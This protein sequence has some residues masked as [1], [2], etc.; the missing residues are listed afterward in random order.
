MGGQIGQITGVVFLMLGLPWINRMLN[1]PGSG[2]WVT[3]YLLF[4]AISPILLGI[5]EVLAAFTEDG[6]GVMPFNIDYNATTFGIIFGVLMSVFTIFY[7]RSFLYAITNH[8]AIYTQHLLPGDGRR[9]LYENINGMRIQRTLLGTFLGY[10]T[11]ITDT[12]NQM[13]M[14]EEGMSVSAGG[15][16]DKKKADLAKFSHL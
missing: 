8:R 3:T 1:T 4:G 16:S 7:Q 11:I 9:I 10:M 5:D 14:V 12:G 6:Q 2:G 15:A 13:E